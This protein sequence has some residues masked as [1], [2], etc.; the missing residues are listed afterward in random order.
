MTVAL[1]I[2]EGFYGPLWSWEERR[3]LVASLVPHGYGFY[4]YAPKA[5]PYLRRRWQEPYPPEQ[6][7]ALTSFA[8]FCRR[9]G[10]RF[11]VGLSPFEIFNQF[12]EPARE[13]LARKLKALDRLGIQ[14]LAILFDD[15]HPQAPDL[16]Q[17][18][19][20]II[21]WVQN[22]T[23][24]EQISVCPTYYSDDP[25]LDRVFGPRPA[26]YLE[27]LGAGL[28]RSVR[29]FWTGEEVCSRE[30]SP[31]HLK[32]VSQRLGRK[33]LLWD[34]YPVNDGDRMSRHLHL[35]GVTGRPAGNAAYLAG[36]AINPALQPVLTTIPAITL[37]ES[38]RQGPDYQYGQ[39]FLHA[40]REVLGAEF[41]AQVHSD[42]LTLQDAGLARISDE[43]KQALIH[44]YDAYDHPAAHEIL[45]WLAG[46]Y[47]V[48][49]EMVATQ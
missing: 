40:A 25:V 8:G 44:T 48:T 19:V 49:D 29:V 34:N 28:D 43:K 18:Q 3:Q 32:R 26:D 23:R 4:L 21:Q 20:N 12:D 38:Y 22:N 7:E 14:E 24:A 27:T 6:A 39:A 33:P 35:R 31:G 2:I 45:R 13:A 1:G 41:A 16:A 46:E 9:E 36:H 17:T 42:L 10:V 30:I 5:D 37:A 11:G 15:M 47:Q